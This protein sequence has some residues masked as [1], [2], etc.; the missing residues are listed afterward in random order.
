[1]HYVGHMPQ[2][3]LVPTAEVARILGRDVRTVHRLVA[4]GQ[5]TPA[6]RAPGI[7]GA[8]LFD[9]A[10]IDALALRIAA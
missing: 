7:R 4:S 2:T 8:L 5:L 9:R 6:V 1:M 3:D 10:D